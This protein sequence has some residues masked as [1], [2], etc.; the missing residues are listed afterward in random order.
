[1][2]LLEMDDKECGEA[3]I[4]KRVFSKENKR[5]HISINRKNS[6]AAIF[7]ER[8]SRKQKKKRPTIYNI[9]I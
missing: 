9:I 8:V 4:A 3:L 5:R 6:A 2:K 7:E 1:M